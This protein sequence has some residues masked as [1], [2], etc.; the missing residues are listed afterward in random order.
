[1][2]PAEFEPIDPVLE[3]AVEE[4]R[5]DSVNPAVIEAAAARV[6]AR[7][8]PQAAPALATVSQGASAPIRNCADFQA[9]LPD[10]R[11]GRLPAARATLVQDHLHECVAC[12]HVNEGKVT[13]MPAERPVQRVASGRHPVRWAVAAAVVATAGVSIWFAVDQYG[14]RTGHPVI[15]ALNGQLYVIAADGIHPLAVGQDLPDGVEIRTAKDSDAMLLLRDGSE[16]EMRERSGFATSGT[17][18]DLTIRLARGS[19][20]VHAAKRRKGHLYVST[21]DCRVAVTGTIFSVTAGAKGSRVSVVEGEVHVSEDNQEK[22][23]H[24]GDQAVSGPSIEPVSVKEDISWSRNRDQL[25]KELDKLRTGLQQ[26]HLPAL[27]YSSR[28]VGHLPASTVFVASIPNLSAYLAEAQSVLH[29]RLDESPELRQWWSE[30]GTN[31]EPMI[32]KLRAASDYLGD[33]IDIAGLTGP[34]GK[35]QP[36]ALI[37]EIRRAGFAEFLKQNAPGFSIQTRGPLV[38]FGPVRESV[39]ALAASL[40]SP[41]SIQGTPFF[42]RIQESFRNGA[43]LLL[44]ADLSRLVPPKEA[45]HQMP[46]VR[47]LVCEQ[48]EVDGQMEMSASL[49]FDG[50]RTGIASWLAEPAPMGSLDYISPDAT[51]VA[52][53]T[54]KSP[55]AILDEMVTLQQRSPEEARKV[56]DNVRRDVGFD[57]HDDLAATLGGEFSVSL[58]GPAFPVPSVKLVA[59]VYDPAR[60]E[61]TV[62]KGV[63]AYNRQAVANG[64]KP[65]RTSQETVDGRV[66]YMI[67]GADPNPLTEVHYTFVDGYLIAG[68][69]RALV[70]HAIQVKTTGANISHSAQFVA[71]EPHD[72]H[73]NFSLVVYQNLGTTLAPL[74]NLLGAFVPNHGGAANAVTGL[75]NMKPLFLAAYGEPDRITVSGNGNGLGQGIASLIGGNLMGVVGNAIPFSPFQGT[76]HA[77]PAFINK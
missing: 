20:L 67:A 33:E 46:S 48:K 16:V 47:Y 41:E 69:T 23:L 36:P 43:G 27:R 56:F 28:L 11:A 38:V 22:I 58:D 72:R 71:L 77:R 5:N 59:E 51:V 12:R 68:L 1:M 7:L 39:E 17:A 10:Y 29:S 13:V 75:A 37:A 54:V 61:A 42:V 49:G 8:A 30:R 40:D 65:L 73:T 32:E 50:Q 26:I 63:E 21:V 3:K 31:V 66:Y 9:L 60:F 64:S 44:C 15:E 14:N 2:T 45:A 34:D 4:I 19:V 25:Y 62:E 35:V 18:G 74:A 24:P 76:H 70:S 55:S 53:A 57:L 52:A 6:W